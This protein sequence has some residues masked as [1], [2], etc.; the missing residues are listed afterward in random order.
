MYKPPT[1]P[2]EGNDMTRGG[3]FLV[4]RAVPTALSGRVPRDLLCTRAEGVRG[5]NNMYYKYSYVNY[6]NGVSGSLCFSGSISHQNF[7]LKLFARLHTVF[8]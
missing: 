2:S 4:H 5:M 8:R 3:K 1:A 7:L 6:Q